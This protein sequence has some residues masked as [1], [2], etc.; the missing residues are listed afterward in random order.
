LWGVLSVEGTSVTAGVVVVDSLVTGVV[1]SVV[2]VVEE[3]VGSLVDVLLVT[4]VVTVELASR[5][6][7]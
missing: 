4:S 1:L 2:V 6:A 3:G 5:V 7:L